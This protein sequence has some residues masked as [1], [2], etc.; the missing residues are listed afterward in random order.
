M[1]N[2][3]KTGILYGIGVGPGDPELVTL[4]AVRIVGECDTVILPAKSKEDCIAYGIMKEACGKIA[5]KELICMPFPMTKDE[6]RLTAA[7]EQICLEIKKLLDNGRQVA[8]LT[9]GDP[10]VYSTYQ[11]IHKRVVKGGYEAHI[12]NGVPSFCAAAGALGISL[13]DNKEEIH[14]IPASY[15]I[16][17]ALKLPGTKVLMKAGKKMKDVKAEL[18]KTNNVEAAAYLG[19]VIAKKAIEK[20]ITSVVFDRGGFIYHG[21]IKAL[22]DAA[23]EA[24]LNF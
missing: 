5:E 23:R 16:E 13:A 2:T 4:K 24:G 1:K 11:Y 3:E 22:A 15:Q 6:S 9:I 10:T 19:T 18:E 20:G 7:H 12:V 14:V 17:D 8:F 21:K